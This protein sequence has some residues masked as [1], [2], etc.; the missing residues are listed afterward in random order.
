[1]VSLL[2]E[3]YRQ[4]KADGLVIP[5]S[6]KSYTNKYF[7]DE[8]IKAWINDSLEPTTRGYIELRQISHLYEEATDNKK[9]IK[10]IR[11]ELIEAGFIVTKNNGDFTLKNWKMKEVENI[12][13]VENNVKEEAPEE[14][15]LV[16]I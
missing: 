14:E 9:T 3:Y 11:A 7:E 13:I 5:R 16:E 2:F 12:N 4:Y 6:V 1:M 8:S 10:Q 15:E